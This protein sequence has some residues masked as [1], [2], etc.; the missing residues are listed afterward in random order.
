MSSNQYKVKHPLLMTAVAALSLTL[1]SSAFARKLPE[2]RFELARQAIEEAQEVDADVVPSGELAL[3]EDKLQEALEYN[4]RGKDKVADR[5]IEQ[6]MLHAELAEL[7]GMQAKADVAFN[8]VNA[9]LR[10]LEIEAARP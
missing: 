1:A 7:Q 9:A 2:E 6:S 8:E 10:S 5:L 4:D 3:A